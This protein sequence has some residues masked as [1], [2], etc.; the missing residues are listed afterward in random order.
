MQAEPT[1][2]STVARLANT[3]QRTGSRTCARARLPAAPSS[4][5]VAASNPSSDIITQMSS[6]S[7]PNTR[8]DISAPSAALAA[9]NATEPTARTRP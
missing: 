8:S 5:H 6:T 7:G 9:T 4:A 1:S 2:A 3:V